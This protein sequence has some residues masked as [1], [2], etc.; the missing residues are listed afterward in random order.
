MQTQFDKFS[1]DNSIAIPILQRDYVQGSDK[2]SEKRNKFVKHLLDA[3]LNNMSNEIDFIFGSSDVG[4]ESTYFIPV[5]GQQR[6][7]TLSLLGWLL[8]QKC[9]NKFSDNLTELTYTSRPSTEQFCKELRLFSLPEKYTKISDYIRKEPGWF[10]YS[11]LGDP[12]INSML[13]LLDYIDALLCGKPYSENIEI[14]AK[15]FFEQSP[16]TFELLDMKSMNLNDD[17]YIKMN[18]RGKLLTPFE[19]WKAEFENFLG[20]HYAK[21]EY[22]ESEIMGGGKVTINEYFEY[23]IE[24]EWCYML[25]PIAL[26]R[27]AALSEEERSMAIYPRIDEAFMNLLD[28]ISKFL[29]Y[30]SFSESDLNKDDI[31]L[32]EHDTDSRRM[33]IYENK[34]NVDLLFRILNTIVA[35][36]NKWG[37]F[38]DF[39]KL[40]FVTNESSKKPKLEDASKVNLYDSPSVDL[41]TLCLDGKMDYFREITLWA[42]IK[43]LISHKEFIGKMDDL[44]SLIDYVRIVVGWARGRNQR[45]TKGLS[46][47][48]NLR[49]THY[50]ESNTIIEEL[51]AGSNLKE[52]LLAT[53]ESSMAEERMKGRLYGSPKFD[54]IRRLS[55]CRSLFYCF[56]LLMPAIEKISDNNIGDFIDKFYEFM[57]L[58]DCERISTLVDHGFQGV[59]TELSNFYFFGVENKWDYIFTMKSNDESFENTKDSLISAILHEPNKTSS[60]P[61]LQYYIT[62]YPDFIRARNNV[63]WPEVKETHY[64]KRNH[65][66]E[67]WMVK[68]FSSNPLQGYNSE[69]FSFVVQQ[70]YKGNA[71][72]LWSESEYSEHGKLWIKARTSESYHLTMECVKNGWLIDCSNRKSKVYQVLLNRFEERVN[73]SGAISLFDPKGEFHFKDNVLLDLANSDRIITALTFIYVLNGLF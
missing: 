42:V 62:R 14:M 57:A 17:L 13:E 7:T 36:Q 44:T 3:L 37:K 33:G 9:G 24:H 49:V 32:Y 1:S 40:I 19:N 53:T 8:N 26:E 58:C 15:R 46:V 29:Y 28:F 12:S 31:D 34:N 52:A 59:R 47:N 43:W 11:W 67:I 21:V 68:T 55:P 48:M 70:L 56:N 18:A 60:I 27:W 10:S 50:K 39:F 4:K 54:I 45:I 72:N 71:L 66:W 64:M 38:E 23:A 73:T 63:R 16:I 6:L 69:P 30:S 5:D 2:N 20:K 65:W 35:I 22:I 61:E 41:M 51:L 25:W